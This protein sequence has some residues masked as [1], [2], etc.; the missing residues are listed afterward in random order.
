ML[1][2]KFSAI[3]ND[4]KYAGLLVFFLAVLVYAN[5]IPNKW[6]IDDG[7]VIH[8]NQ[9][10]QRGFGGIPDILTH[11]FLYGSNGQNTD[12]VSGGRWRPLTPV[13]YAVFSGMLGKP[14]TNVK[15]G[16][17]LTDKK[18]NPLNDLGENTLFPI[19][20][21]LLNVVLYAVLCLVLY[22]FLR[23]IFSGV[24]HGQ[25]IA[26][27]AAFFFT[28]HPV[29]TE[30]V[31]NAKG[32]DEILAL[33]FALLAAGCFFK[34]FRENSRGSNKAL[35][36]GTLFFFLGLLAKENAI[37]F[38]FVIPLTLWFFTKISRPQL[39]KAVG[40]LMLPTL[41][42]LGL[43][44]NAIGES[45]ANPPR[46]MMNNPFLVLN[47]ASQYRPLLEGSSIM[48]LQN[49]GS[50]SL[51]Q[52]PYSNQLATTIY[53]FGKYLQL[54][55]VPYP[56][57]YDYYPGQVA[58]HSF[59]DLSVL[60]SLLLHVGLLLIGLYGLQSR[61]LYSYGIL[62]YC[63]TF[64]LVSNLFFPIGTNMAERFLFMPSVGAMIAVCTLLVALMQRFARLPIKTVL[65]VAALVYIG[66]TLRRNRDWKDNLT[67]FAHDLE[68]SVNSA[69]VK[70]DYGEAVL[71][72]VNEQSAQAISEGRDLSDDEKQQQ[73]LWL[74]S[75]LPHYEKALQINPMFGLVWFNLARTEQILGE[76]EMISPV[77]RLSH[78]Q[79]AVAAYDVTDTYRPSGYSNVLEAYKSLCYMALGKLYGQHYHN[80][81]KALH[82]LHLAAKADPSNAH[83]DFLLGTAYG[84][85]KDSRK[86]YYYTEKAYRKDTLNRDFR[87]NYALVLQKRAV[88]GGSGSSGLRNAEILLLQVVVQNK[89]LPDGDAS[90]K[91]LSVRT[92]E[93]LYEN[94]LLQ[95]DTRKAAQ[96]QSQLQALR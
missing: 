2:N 38:L 67:L 32:S 44:L 59:A 34:A 3:I 14:A 40:F 66:I 69:K 19:V 64:A 36:N 11:D 30:V 86:S 73:I 22:R 91:A 87:E 43:R 70:S 95:H 18:G 50:G 20:M 15:T 12:A 89:S 53:T 63:I 82:F 23:R 13:M 29:H 4:K 68:I 78:L 42:Y 71:S 83:A 81:D 33:L 26:F 61:R 21:H 90:K 8:K 96:V 51:E 46:D 79:T 56:L 65:A 75:T 80:L 85:K 17:I 52:M 35:W 39:L 60:L 94:Y 72:K 6:T 27:L 31:A 58:M 76:Q 45:T 62:W 55:V 49:P 93:L 24:A 10:V 84:I 25:L 48:V 7:L 77:K 92:L 9:L 16:A 1:M 57:T 88:N 54:L 41:I 74:Q 47:P 37:M 28:I 5:T